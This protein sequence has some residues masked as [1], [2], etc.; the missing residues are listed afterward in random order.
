MARPS[1][2]V[3]YQANAAG[4]LITIRP[5]TADHW[6]VWW[7]ERAWITYAGTT[8]DAALDGITMYERPFLEGVHLPGNSR[9]LRLPDKISEWRKVKV[10]K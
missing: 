10:V 7:D 4:H 6:D 9:T 2:N 3:E 8:P 5:G 1:R